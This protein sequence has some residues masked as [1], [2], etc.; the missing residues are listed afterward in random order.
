MKA[1]GTTD[2]ME[3]IDRGTG[4]PLVLIPGVQGRWEYM[5]PAVDALSQHFRVITFSLAGER[6][7]GRP[8]DGRRG[9]DDLADQV[10]A[11]LDNRGIDA[12]IV[13]GVS[14]GGLVALRFAAARP[15]RVKALVLVSTPA[16]GWHLRPRHDLYARM[17]WLFGP[18]F[19]AESP[20]RMRDELKAAFPDPAARRRFKREQLRTFIEAPLSVSRMATRARLIAK[21]DAAAQCRCVSSPT[22]VVTG[23]PGLDHVIASDAGSAYVRLI[24]SARAAVLAGTGHLGLV[25]KP[26]AFAAAIR[27][28]AD[29]AL[30]GSATRKAHD[31]A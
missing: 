7:A 10:D 24:P 15:A 31:A 28:F 1:M 30:G 5:R 22:L 26:G 23:E 27:T 9:F 11:V 2:T 19:L 12:A 14:F 13:C 25:T 6:A 16:P 29:S 3:V 4:V 18:V 20:W 17:P 8:Y 21:L